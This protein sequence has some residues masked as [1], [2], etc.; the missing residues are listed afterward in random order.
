M[1]LFHSKI[2]CIFSHLRSVTRTSDRDCLYDHIRIYINMF[3]CVCVCVCSRQRMTI[4]YKPGHFCLLLLLLS[5]IKNTTICR[6]CASWNERNYL[7][8]LIGL[9]FT[10]FNIYSRIYAYHLN[11]YSESRIQP[12]LKL[13]MKHHQ[14]LSSIV[15]IIFWYTQLRL[16]AV[17]V[18]FIFI[19]LDS[20]RTPSLTLSR[21]LSFFLRN[22]EHLLTMLWSINNEFVID[23]FLAYA[24]NNLESIC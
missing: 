10:H 8:E 9:T 6:L 23:R 18:C 11:R 7:W 13:L 20:S 17:I 2:A 15:K 16:V 21:S 5:I 24:K 1:L 4:W 12:S 14:F 22:V 19:C 3:T